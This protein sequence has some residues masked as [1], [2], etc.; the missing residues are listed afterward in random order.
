MTND[1]KKEFGV[2]RETGEYVGPW[3]IRSFGYRLLSRAF[4]REPDQTF[5]WYLRSTSTRIGVRQVA[6]SDGLADRLTSG[7]WN[8]KALSLEF[9]RLFIGPPALVSPYE[10]LHRPDTGNGRLWGDAA[11]AMKRFAESLGLRYRDDRNDMPD[12]VSIELELMARLIEAEADAW[13]KGNEK[14]AAN[15][16]DAQVEF[17]RRHLSGWFPDFCRQ[18]RSAAAE[19]FYAML[20]DL[21]LDFWEQEQL[22]LCCVKI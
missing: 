1:I 10:S 21:A 6:S 11:V 2:T 17:L 4:R 5:L 20:A 14:D 9:C 12:H 3:E 15:A 7:A 18:L 16:Q 22:Y 19:P 13:D 8:L